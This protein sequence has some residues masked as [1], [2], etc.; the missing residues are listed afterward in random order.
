M[1][2]L[3]RIVQINRAQHPGQ[4]VFDANPDVQKHSAGDVCHHI[5]RRSTNDLRLANIKSEIEAIIDHILIRVGYDHVAEGKIDRGGL[6]GRLQRGVDR[7][8][9]RPSGCS[10]P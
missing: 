8:G 7:G 5:R 6:V 3:H 4:F 1:A 9:R 2:Q 10:R